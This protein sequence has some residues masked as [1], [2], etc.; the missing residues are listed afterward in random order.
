MIKRIGKAIQ[1]GFALI[2]AAS[3]LIVVVFLS[4]GIYNNRAEILS[5][6][7]KKPAPT[8][9]PVSTCKFLGCGA[10]VGCPEG[11]GK[12]EGCGSD[13][14]QA[15][16]CTTPTVNTTVQ[17]NVTQNQTTNNIE[18]LGPDNK[19]F[20][21]SMKECEDL[22]RKWGKEPDYF[23]NCQVHAACGG[24]TKYML[25]STCGK[26]YCCMYRDGRNV[27]LYDKSQC[28]DSSLVNIN[29]QNNV[30]TLGNNT[31]CW[32]NSYGY[33]YYTSSGDQ[34]NL[35]NAKSGTNKACMDSQKIKSDSCATACQNK[36]N[37]DRAIC[38]WAYT[39]PDAGIEQNSDKY[40]ECLNGVGGI[41]EDYSI[42]LGKCTEQYSQDIKQCN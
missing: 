18:C 14:C 1:M 30:K 20:K 37:E 36:L 33:G 27:F 28:I 12:W 6:F 40:G 22:N 19:Q 24:G 35:D 17:N 34:C 11:E 15:G 32:N 26:T 29:T 41:G 3:V 38:A 25:K 39:G 42:C 5:S 31:Y 2:G 21:T 7:Q 8:S 23:V 9:A 10:A 16:R 4:A 13:K